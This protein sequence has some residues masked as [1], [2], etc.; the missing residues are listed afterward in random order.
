MFTRTS[1]IAALTLAATAIT[2][3]SAH[4]IVNG[5]TAAAGDFPFM[6]QVRNGKQST[7][8]SGSLIAPSYV[9]TAAHCADEAGAGDMSV[10]VGNVDRDTG[11]VPRRVAR[12][13]RHPKYYGNINTI[14][15]DVALLELSHPITTIAPLPLAGPTY[16][17][18]W[19]G[20]TAFANYDDGYAAGWGG[21]D[22]MGTSASKLQWTGTRILAP[23]TDVD[24]G[25]RMIPVNTSMCQGDSGS[26]LIVTV[27]GKYANAGVHT[28]ALCGVRGLYA[29]V[30]AGGNRS[31]V[32]SNMNKL[33]YTYFGAA[34][35]DRDGHQDQL[36]RQEST[37]DLL[38]VPGQSR[39]STSPVLPVKIGNGYQG[40]TSFGVADWDRDGHQDLLIRHDVSGDLFLQKGTSARG[41]SSGG[42]T[43]IG[44]GF[45]DTTPFGVTDWDRDGHQDL[46]VREDWGGSLRLYAGQSSSTAQVTN[47]Y[48]IGTGWNGYTSFGVGD[49]D[50]D[51]HQD[52]IARN[53]SHGSSPLSLF[54]GQS[55]RAVSTNPAVRIGEG[56]AGYSPFGLT[57]WDR[58]GHQDLLTR[59]DA[60]QKLFLVPGVSYR[61]PSNSSLIQIGTGY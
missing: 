46:L 9:L 13:I 18:L 11:G 19:D 33:A 51:G 30:A 37:G 34:D 2:V 27:N 28:N 32:T 21:I 10:R 41:Y 59:N 4:A 16:T 47:P 53:N 40:Y 55:K 24:T 50:R 43:Q 29:E 44:T 48:T 25:M 22:T 56:W 26:P 60:S 42:M 31:F 12:L 39:R 3:P 5:R 35:W 61:G 6:A 1:L 14:G 52:L 49:W 17:H 15:T 58:D 36:V 54:P 20:A 45:A 38:L 8:C 7:S 23:F 57:D